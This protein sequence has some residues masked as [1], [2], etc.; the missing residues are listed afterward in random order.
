[1]TNAIISSKKLCFKCGESQ[2]RTEFYKHS[3]MSDGLLGKCKTCT[4]KD[5]LQH[6]LDN[7]EKVREYDRQRAKNP[8]RANLLH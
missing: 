7:L 2:P 1:M 5:A 6:R 8:G 3:A 4:K